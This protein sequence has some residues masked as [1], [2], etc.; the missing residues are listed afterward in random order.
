MEMFKVWDVEATEETKVVKESNKQFLLIQ[1][2]FSILL[3]I[4]C[5]F[6][7]F[8]IRLFLFFHVKVFLAL[9]FTLV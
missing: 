4:L 6:Q 5:T 3:Q 9:V 8:M 2:N 1:E 7:G